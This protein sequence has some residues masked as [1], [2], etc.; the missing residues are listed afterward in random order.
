MH[1]EGLIFGCIFCCLEVD[2]PTAWGSYTWKGLY[3]KAT[4]YGI[5][6]LDLIVSAGAGTSEGA[7]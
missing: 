5:P 7:G 4:V 3:V 6:S 2:W 1:L